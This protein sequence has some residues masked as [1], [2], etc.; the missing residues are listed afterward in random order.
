VTNFVKLNFTF[1]LLEDVTPHITSKFCLSKTHRYVIDNDHQLWISDRYT[2]DPQKFTV[3]MCMFYPNDQ[4][5][6]FIGKTI[7]SYDA[8]KP[9]IKKY[10]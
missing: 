4:T 2:A 1:T 3:L 8:I 5:K 9:F 6:G 7:G 10:A